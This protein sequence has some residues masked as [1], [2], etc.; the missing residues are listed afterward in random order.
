MYIYKTTNKVNGK[1]YIG[2]SEKKFN[3]TYFGSG[4][5]L[6]KAI[7]K[8]GVEKFLIEMI[9]QCDD[10]QTLNEREKFWINE[11][12]D[13]SYNIAE[14]GTGGWTTKFYNET[15]LNNYK[16]KLRESKVNFTISEETKRKISN[17]NK[18]RVMGNR[19]KQK[20]TIKNMWKDPNSIYN[21]IEYR[22]NLSRSLKGHEVSEETREKIR[23][24]KLGSKNGMAIKIKVDDMVFETRRECAAYFGISE[25]A[26]SKRCKSKHFVNWVIV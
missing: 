26:V 9:E 15:Q 22:E 11:Y 5:L 13:H 10:T 8:Y 3:K 2:K 12:K 21:S 20:E 24:T 25:T 16:Q 18:G 19:E 14:G 17:A 23:Q 7:K 4:I 6:N 1:V